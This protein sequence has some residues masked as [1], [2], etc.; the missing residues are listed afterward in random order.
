MR[1]FLSDALI[2]YLIT[3][4]LA[5]DRKKRVSEESKLKDTKSGL[6]LVD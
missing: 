2:L 6:L 3:F 1:E 4:P 5:H